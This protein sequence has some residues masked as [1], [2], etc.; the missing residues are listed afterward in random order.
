MKNYLITIIVASSLIG[1]GGKSSSTKTDTPIADSTVT[2]DIIQYA[3][4]GP[5]PLIDLESDHLYDM[6]FPSDLRLGSDGHLDLTGFPNP[7]NLKMVSNY[8]EYAE[9]KLDGFSLTP[10]ISFR[11]DDSINPYT[12]TATVETRH[13]ASAVQ[14]INVDPA[15][16]EYGQRTA[17]QT[18]WWGTEEAVYIR[19][20][21]LTLQP[22]FGTPLL[23]GTT[24][25]AIITRAVR[26]D[27]DRLITQNPIVG[28]AL[29]NDSGPLSD[30]LNP[31]RVW[32]DS[33]GD[34]NPAEI[35]TASVFT[36]G[37]PTGELRAIRDYLRTEYPKPSVQVTVVSQKQKHSEYVIYEGFY[38]AP[39]FQ[40]GEKPYDEG[41]EILFDESGKPIVGEVEQLQFA[42]SVPDAP[43]PVNGWPIVIYGHGTGGDYRSFLSGKVYPVARELAKEGYAVISIDQ[44]LHGVRFQGDIDLDIYSFNYVNARAGVSNFRQ[45]AIDVMSLVRLIQNDFRIDASVSSTGEEINFDETHISYFGHSH[46]ALSGTMVAALETDILGYVLSA[47]GGGLSY[48]LVLRKDPFDIK[49]F[50]AATLSIT[51]PDELTI[52][53]PVMALAQNLADRTDPLTYAPLYRNPG[54]GR[55]PVNLFLTEG[56]LDIQTPAVTTDNLAAAAHM[57]IIE[58][59]IKESI[60]HT[61]LGMDPV[62]PPV[63]GNW[64]NDHGMS[65]AVLARFDADD[66]FAIFSNT[67]AFVLYKSFLNSLNKFGL[68]RIE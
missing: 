48:T 51:N 16:A 41:G 3:D 45:S 66:H 53:H 19:P 20:H 50:M 58:D 21:T 52:A 12:V 30:V 15:S 14:I 2:P 43:T 68:P 63:V 10:S 61:L 60:A 5:T 37:N 11:F 1:C 29:L 67:S 25:A 7:K 39:N 32:L 28:E 23:A 38:Q 59:E 13:A 35:A 18:H 9:E 17:V 49:A 65:T 6:P 36:T 57:P 33:K 56:T 22:V 4:G 55:P 62:K 8:V 40:S 26:D 27:T 42:V 64:V 47:A 44:P 31:L 46:G 24:Y 34:V 54:D